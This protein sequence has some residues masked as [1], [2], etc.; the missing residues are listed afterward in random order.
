[1]VG[2]LHAAAA[3]VVILCDMGMRSLRVVLVGDIHAA[4]VQLQ[5]GAGA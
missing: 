4:C 5:G 2:D 1:L 3:R